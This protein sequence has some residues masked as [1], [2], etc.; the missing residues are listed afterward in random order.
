MPPR[1][2]PVTRPN[3]LELGENGD[4]THPKPLDILVNGAVNQESTQLM[5]TITQLVTTMVQDRKA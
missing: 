5:T 2:N 4:D 1:R 3:A